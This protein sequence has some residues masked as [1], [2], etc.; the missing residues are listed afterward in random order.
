MRAFLASCFCCFLDSTPALALGTASTPL[1]PALLASCSSSS[2][3]SDSES[4]HTVA[5]SLS[6]STHSQSWLHWTSPSPSVLSSKLQRSSSVTSCR[7]PDSHE[8]PKI[9]SALPTTAHPAAM[10]PRGA[11]EATPATGGAVSPE[12]TNARASAPP[13]LAR[14]SAGST[15]ESS[16]GTAVGMPVPGKGQSRDQTAACPCL[17][18]SINTSLMNS[19]ISLPA[20]AFGF[21]MPE[22]SLLGRL[23]SMTP[24]KTRRR[25]GECCE[26]AHWQRPVRRPGPWP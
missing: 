21:A 17:Q 23:R 8:P 1:R 24:P 20:F 2:S 5:R 25:P 3:L 13:P 26:T 15:V 4:N 19:A 16:A 11:R 6:G 7:G 18:S 14:R 22:D 9:Q 12:T 10:R